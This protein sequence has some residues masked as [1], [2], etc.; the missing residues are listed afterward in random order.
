[1]I[2][3]TIN[4]EPELKLSLEDS[5][6]IKGRENTFSIRI[7]NFGLADVKFVYISIGQASGI[8]LLSEKEKYLGD[9]DSNDFDSVDYKIYVNSDAPN[10][11]TLPVNL[12]YRDATNKKFSENRILNLN[13][14]SLEEAQKLGLVKKTNFGIY[15][16]ILILVI[17]YIIYRIIRKRRKKKK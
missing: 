14:Y 3:V 4:A 12:E 9:I 7:T 2:S 15:A 8:N 17:G 10:T 5:T 1:L 13:F 16:L 6:L 11:V